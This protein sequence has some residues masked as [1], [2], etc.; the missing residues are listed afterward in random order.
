MTKHRSKICVCCSRSL[1]DEFSMLTNM[2]KLCA[3]H[4]NI[5]YIKDPS[6]AE[7]FRT[8]YLNRIDEI[9]EMEFWIEKRQIKKWEGD[10]S[11]ILSTIS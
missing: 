4:M 5:E 1:T 7:E 11:G 10:H 6:Q 3:R 9:G 8:R 2:G